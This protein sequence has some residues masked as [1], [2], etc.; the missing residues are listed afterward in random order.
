MKLSLIIITTLILVI[1][2][3][4]DALEKTKVKWLPVIG[5]SNKEISVF[6]NS[7]SEVSHDSYRHAEILISFKKDTDIKIN[8]KMTPVRSTVRQLMTD[9]SAGITISLSDLF[10]N[11]PMPNENDTVISFINYNIVIGNLMFLSK[12]SILYQ[13]LCPT[14]I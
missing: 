3:W 12:N 8:D 4:S 9:C 13:T 6:I 5:V 7:S 10:Y 14:Y 2:P 1:T 11:K